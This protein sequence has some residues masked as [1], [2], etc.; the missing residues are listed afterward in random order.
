M[1]IMPETKAAYLPNL[2]DKY[3]L[4]MVKPKDIEIKLIKNVET[5]VRIMLSPAILAPIPSPMLFNERATA[6]EKDSFISILPEV[7]LSALSG[8]DRIS[9]SSKKLLP[10]LEV[11]FLEELLNS[12]KIAH[13][14]II[15]SISPPIAFVKACGIKFIINLPNSIDNIVPI[16]DIRAM[17]ILIGRVIFIFFI[18]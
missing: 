9:S 4:P 13:K 17:I 2:L 11:D 14:P 5:D 8:L 3:L 6:R 10:L 16:E 15:I 7:S 18:P 1:I 12:L